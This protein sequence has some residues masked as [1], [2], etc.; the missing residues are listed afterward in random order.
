MV[1]ISLKR[2]SKHATTEMLCFS[3]A[4]EFL[5]IQTD[6]N[7][8]LVIDDSGDLQITSPV[9]SLIQDV[10][11]RVRTN[12]NEYSS[13]PRF[14]SNLVTLVGEANNE[15]TI[16]LVREQVAESLFLDRRFRRSAG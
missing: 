13:A 14:G 2:F 12:F 6:I 7:G 9:Q 5:D 3:V 15:R 1:L 8:D 10:I 11:F 4:Q 16:A